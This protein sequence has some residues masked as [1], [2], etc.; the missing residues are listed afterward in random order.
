MPGTACSAS[1]PPPLAIRKNHHFGDDPVE[2]RI[3]QPLLDPHALAIGAPVDP[4]TEIGAKARL[5]FAAHALAAC[6]RGE[7][8]APKDPQ[9]R[10][11]VQVSGGVVACESGF[12]DLCRHLLVSQ[13]GCNRNPLDPRV[14]GFD[15]AA[16]SAHVE[17]ERERS[18]FTPRIERIARNH[19]IGEHGDLVARHVHRGHALAREQIER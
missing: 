3:A 16:I 8:H 5:G 1:S 18:H 13:I 6:H 9:R 12:G 11:E 15:V 4:E 7:R 17:V 14:R 2:W 19:R 10:T